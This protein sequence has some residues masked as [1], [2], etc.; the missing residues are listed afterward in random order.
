MGRHPK[1]PQG[2]NQDA[3]D[4]KPLRTLAPFFPAHLVFDNFNQSSNP[5][6]VC[7]TPFGPSSGDFGSPIPSNFSPPVPSFAAAQPQV[8][9]VKRPR[10]RPP[11]I[12]SNGS[13]GPIKATPIS[14]FHTPPSFT[15]MDEEDES[16]FVTETS[17]RGRKIKRPSR[18]G[19]SSAERSDSAKVKKVKPL[20][21]VRKVPE[22]EIAALRVS[23]NDPREN[24]EAIMMIFD[25]LRRRLLQ[26]DESSNLNGRQD[27]KAGAIMLA[28][29]LK[30]NA[31]KRIGPVPG[32]EVGDIFYFRMEMCIIGLHAPS[33]AGIDY[34]TAK[35]DNQD[36]PVAI[37]IVS[38]GGYENEEDDVDFLIYTGQ[39]GSTKNEDQKLERGNLAL[40][41]SLYRK[42]QIRVVRSAKDPNCQ[43]GKIYYYDGLYKIQ[44]SWKEKAK[45]G[46]NVFK[47]KLLREPGQPEGLAVWKMTQKWKENPSGRGRVILSDLSSGTENIP[48]CL[49]NDVD[50][51]K[52]PTH[53]T[54]ITKVKYLK[55]ISLMKPLQGCKCQSVCLPGDI[56][57]SCAQQNEGD[58][59]YSSLGLLVSRK[60]LIA[61]CG[62]S[63]QCSF[64]CR[65]RVTQKGIRLHFEVFKTRDRGWGLRSWDPIRAGTFICEYT[66]ELIDEVRVDMNDEEDDYIFQT[67]YLGEKT[68]RWNRGTE[69][70]GEPSTNE[71]TEAQN[72]L[73]I[74]ITAKSMG[75]IARFMNHSCSPNVLW[76]P[77]LHDHG[78]EGH[79]H[80]MF[81]A[82]KHIPPM[83]ELTYDYGVSGSN[84]E[85]IGG[86]GSR[87]AKKCLCASPNCRGFFG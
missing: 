19:S 49:V 21:P 34:M 86:F 44:N 28:N 36:D 62:S 59:P 3:L 38:S 32:V 7:I 70:L 51:E 47:Y 26:L 63:C 75:N 68:S 9:P 81:F 23:Y 45:S 80:I 5:P 11:K 18:L 40:E 55:P 13:N 33:M 56:N 41:R 1:N 15:E 4:V 17:S 79:A 42:N 2:S 85:R 29:D 71:S 61:E 46:I 52:G 78:D 69:L 53:F 66:G 77:V 22:N 20:K 65:N 14:A 72:L 6:L 30:A 58:L 39:G 76:Q 10:G 16:I 24:V 84:D 35:F 87:R 27:L 73:P 48:V 12:A 8:T 67:A 54:Y 82:L 57:C 25:A 64:N 74:T 43:T 37:C 83:T 50:N 60:P 31:G